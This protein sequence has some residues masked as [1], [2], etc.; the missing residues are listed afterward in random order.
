M[1][2][3][4]GGNAYHPTGKEKSVEAILNIHQH[5]IQD[6]S[7]VTITAG[8][9]LDIRIDNQ[10]HILLITKGTIKACRR[11]DGIVISNGG[12]PMILGLVDAYAD[13]YQ[14][15]ESSDVFFIAETT[16]EYYP[17][18]V[19]DFVKKADEKQLW[20]DIS[21]ILMYRI[22]FMT[23][24]D[25][26]LI[27]QDAY[28]QI[29]AL[30]LELWSHPESSRFEINAQ[31]FIQQ[32]TGLSRSRIMQ[33]LSELKAGNYIKILHGRLLELRNLPDSF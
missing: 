20:R 29:K 16:C 12:S 23:N 5:F 10:S 24:R 13:L 18:P 8:K 7:P 4:N 30:L 6:Y 15:A 28:S 19:K 2:Q 3:L 33:V 22:A 14:L 32:R 26:N 27:G 9:T 17:I 21:N 31:N 11:V 1:K 25:R